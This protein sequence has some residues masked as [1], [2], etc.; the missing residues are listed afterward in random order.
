MNG[1]HIGRHRTVSGWLPNLHLQPSLFPWTP[2]LCG[3]LSTCYFRLYGI[4]TWISNRHSNLT[5]KKHDQ[6]SSILPF[7]WS[8][9][10]YLN[11]NFKPWHSSWLRFLS[12]PIPNLWEN[13]SASSPFKTHSDS[14]HFLW[15]LLLP[16][17]SKPLFSFTWITATAY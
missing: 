2:D 1:Y 8:S 16:H 17:W 9:P 5:C 13:L 7:Q 14:D 3:Q 11:G 6:F 10:F 15:P 4:C 12:C